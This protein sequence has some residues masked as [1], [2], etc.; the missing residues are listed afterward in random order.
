MIVA[1]TSQL[2][3]LDWRK[4]ILLLL[5]LF[6]LVGPQINW[7]TQ[8]MVSTRKTVCIISRKTIQAAKTW[9]SPNLTQAGIY[10]YNDMDTCSDTCCTS[11]NWKLVSFSN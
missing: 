7:K 1:Y 10:G 4:F 5:C 6:L 2:G 8:G 11:A 9:Q 3:N